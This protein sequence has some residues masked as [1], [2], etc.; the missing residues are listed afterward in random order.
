MHCL[1]S[2]ANCPPTYVSVCLSSYSTCLSVYCMASTCSFIF[3]LLL[4]Y[5]TSQICMACDH[6]PAIVPATL[7]VAVDY[8]LLESVWKPRLTCILPPVYLLGVHVGYWCGCPV[9]VKTL[10]EELAKEHYQR[11]LFE[12]EV[13]VCSRLHHPN[14][15][16]I[17]GVIQQRDAPFSLIM[18][19]LQASLADVIE[20]AHVSGK[21]LTLREQTDVSHDCLSGLTYLHD[22]VGVNL[23]S[24]SDCVCFCQCIF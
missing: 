24:L 12:Q 9:A 4:L 2:A 5:Q 6:E 3:S 10:H 21:Y 23:L 11:R 19:L 15:A 8:F 13:S 16:A 1:V 22:L 17:C 14:I 18:E 20:A 7:L